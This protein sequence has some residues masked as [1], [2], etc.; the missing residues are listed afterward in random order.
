MKPLD[1]ENLVLETL[2][3]DSSEP[4][5]LQIRNRFRDL[6]LCGDLPEGTRLPAERKLAALLGVNRTTVSNAYHELAADGL[7]K[8]QVGHGTIVRFPAGNTALDDRHLPPQ[9]FPWNEHFVPTGEQARNPI[10][11]ELVALCARKDVISLAAGVPAP[12]LYPL[13][14]FAQALDQVLSQHGQTLLQHCPTEGHLAFR[15]TLAELAAQRGITASPENVLVLTGSQQGLDLIA[16]ALIKPGDPVV[17]ETPSY[18]GALSAFR[19]AGARLLGVPMDREGLRTDVLERLLIRYR[20]QLI[21][22]L[23]TFQNPSGRVM[24]LERRQTLLSLAQRYQVPILEDDPYGELYYDEPPPPPLK[25]LD[26]QGHAIYLSTFSKILFPGIRLGWL[27]APR[28]VVDRL[29][30]IKQY[31]DLH[32]NT[33]AQWAVTEFIHRGWLDSHLVT[34][35]REYPR[36]RR[37]M[38]DALRDLTPHG[39]YWNEPP[40][41]FYVWCRLGQGLRSRELLTEA[42]RRRV[43]FVLGE[44]F[45]ADGDGQDTFRLNFTYHSERDIQ[46]GIRRLSQALAT[47]RRGRRKR[48]AI[49]PGEA[50][51]IV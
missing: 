12:A 28:P 44:P 32:T 39:L 4:L 14:R 29:A 15:E 17:V 47:L 6:I 22:T 24:S 42:V 30:S 31:T 11:R 13:E 3:R 19:A 1:T 27:V 7:V 23:P 26:R 21:Y 33:L 50:R 41:G 46:E 36:R 34:L 18:L 51:P 35:R 43:V 2:D 45:Y 9:P 48:P 16:R 10:I 20:P 37:A 8:G 38:L 40:G 49:Q 25:S 5:Y